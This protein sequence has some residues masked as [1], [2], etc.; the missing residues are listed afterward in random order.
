[1]FT[2]SDDQPVRCISP[3][4]DQERREIPDVVVVGDSCEQCVSDTTGDSRP[5][6]ERA[7]TLDPITDPGAR[8]CHNSRDSIWRDRH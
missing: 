6:D 5:N 2:P 4:C 3:T 8:A 1:M 7:A